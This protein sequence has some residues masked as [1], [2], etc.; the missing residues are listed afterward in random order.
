[1]STTTKA[2]RWTVEAVTG[3]VA[4]DAAGRGTGPESTGRVYSTHR[5]Q[6]AAERAMEKHQDASPL[7]KLAVFAR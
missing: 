2:A 3:S 7:V 1:M 5:T 6:A 4:V